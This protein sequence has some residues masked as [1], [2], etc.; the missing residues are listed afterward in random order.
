MHSIHVIQSINAKWQC[1]IVLK[2]NTTSF[3][4]PLSHPNDDNHNPCNHS[5]N[6]LKCVRVLQSSVRSR[7]TT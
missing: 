1:E 2:E 4:I 5:E 6:S 3:S 7:E